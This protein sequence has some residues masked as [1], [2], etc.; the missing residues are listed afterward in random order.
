MMKRG[1]ALERSYVHGINME[2]RKVKGGQVILKKFYFIFLDLFADYTGCAISLLLCT[3]SENT[4]TQRH[5]VYL[6]PLYCFVQCHVQLS[7]QIKGIKTI[8]EHF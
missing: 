7:Y 8:K 5:I 6:L 2:I 3:N 1:G 4:K